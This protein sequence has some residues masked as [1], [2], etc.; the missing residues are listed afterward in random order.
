[1]QKEFVTEIEGHQKIGACIGPG[2][3]P[4]RKPPNSP[5][6]PNAQKYVAFLWFA[7]ETNTTHGKYP[8][9]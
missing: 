3:V 5:V 4:L 8:F 6:T 7:F 1:M 2:L 9:R